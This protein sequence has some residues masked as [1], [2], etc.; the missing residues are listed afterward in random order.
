MGLAEPVEHLLGSHGLVGEE[1]LEV[2]L[3]RR[4]GLVGERPLPEGEENVELWT[5][6]KAWRRQRWMQTNPLVPKEPLSGA[7]D[8]NESS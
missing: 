2:D 8:A 1:V 7:L 6:K 5:V 3:R 4:Q